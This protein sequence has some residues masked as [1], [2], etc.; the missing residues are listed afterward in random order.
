MKRRK[1]E[2]PRLIVLLRGLGAEHGLDCCK[3]GGEGAS[4]LPVGP[5]AVARYCSSI[6]PDCQPLSCYQNFCS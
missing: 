1:W 6:M 2:S 5:S 4:Y 3:M